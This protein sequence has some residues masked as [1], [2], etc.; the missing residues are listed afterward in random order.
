[1]NTK[2]ISIKYYRKHC[3]SN[4]IDSK[5]DIN[6]TILLIILIFNQLVDNKNM[7]IKYYRNYIGR[8]LFLC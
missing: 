6:F 5:V 1:M 3:H 2:S 4:I 8:K 7:N